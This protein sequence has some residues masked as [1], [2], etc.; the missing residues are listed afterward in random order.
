MGRGF[1]E[2]ELPDSGNS[3]WVLFLAFLDYRMDDGSKLDVE[4]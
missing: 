1:I 2:Y 3:A 4:Q